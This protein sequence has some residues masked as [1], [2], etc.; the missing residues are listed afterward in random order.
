MK[1]CCNK[2]NKRFVLTNRIKL[3]FF[4][5]LC[6]V[7]MFLIVTDSIIRSIIKDYPMTVATGVMT[8]MMDSAMDNVLSIAKLEPSDVDDVLYSKDGNVI[9]VETNTTEL[10]KI[11][12]AFSEKLNEKLN[13]YGNVIQVKIPIGTIIG[14]EYT[15]GKGPKISFNLQFSCTVNTELKSVFYDAG[16]NN[17]LHSVELNVTNNIYIIIPWGYSSETVETSYIIAETVIVGDVPDAFT[18][19]NGAD[20][21]I[22]D[23]IVDHGAKLD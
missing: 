14:N 12:T 7:L 20:D 8:K 17:T 1:Y 4:I 10:V 18:N 19:I 2:R 22:T 5:V 16:V 9:S 13:E 3:G 11:K 15:L 6:G 23:D 21:E